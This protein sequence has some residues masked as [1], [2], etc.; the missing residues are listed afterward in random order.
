MWKYAAWL[1]V[2]A[3][4]KFLKLLGHIMVLLVLGIV[5][6]TWYAVVPA[7][8]GPMMI[9]GSAGSKFGSSLLVLMFS[10]LVSAVA[11]G[12]CMAHA[13]AH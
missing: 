3:Y 2:F 4:C 1:D 13:P 12:A 9:S 8:Y 10:G 5:G 11:A 7:T 6:F